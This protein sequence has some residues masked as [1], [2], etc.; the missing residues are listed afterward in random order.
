ME[1]IMMDAK[2]T[3]AFLNMSLTWIYRDA[4]KFGLRGYKFGRGKNAKIQY[5]KV[6]VL[7]WLEQQKV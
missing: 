3:A 1:T 5:K 2:Q 6:D 4:P 7:K